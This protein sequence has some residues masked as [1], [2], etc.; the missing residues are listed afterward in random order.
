MRAQK[1]DPALVSQFLSHLALGRDVRKKGT[2]AV[3][4]PL[5]PIRSDERGSSN[6]TVELQFIKKR[7]SRLH[8]AV[9]DS[10][11]E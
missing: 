7:K 11:R 3:G 1:R 6:P 5:P 9:K 2:A 8:L 4:R 10:E